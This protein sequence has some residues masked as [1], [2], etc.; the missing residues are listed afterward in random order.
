[1]LGGGPTLTLSRGGPSSTVLG[2]GSAVSGR[3]PALL[4]GGSSAPGGRP[5]LPGGSLA[6]PR[7]RAARV[8]IVARPVVGAPNP[9]RGPIVEGT[10]VHLLPP[11]S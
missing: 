1:M 3:G 11:P 9:I 8:G 4:A 7:G 6:V 10:Q 5:S 2:G